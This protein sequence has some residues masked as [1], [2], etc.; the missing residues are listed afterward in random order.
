[1]GLAQRIQVLLDMCAVMTL[2]SCNATH[3]VHRLS[4]K[5]AL[6]PEAPTADSKNSDQSVD[7][8]AKLS[9]HMLH[10]SQEHLHHNDLQEVIKPENFS[11]IFINY[12]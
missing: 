7:V 2:I 4:F 10:M 9:F 12:L 5:I 1:M 3:S 8:Q 6:H 11:L